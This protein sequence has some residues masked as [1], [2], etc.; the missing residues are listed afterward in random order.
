M[1]ALRPLA[2]LVLTL[3]VTS[4]QEEASPFTL[5]LELQNPTPLTFEGSGGV[6]GYGVELRV[7]GLE[8]GQP[9]ILDP[10]CNGR[11]CGEA[12]LTDPGTCG[13]SALIRSQT[14][15]PIAWDGRYLPRSMDAFGECLAPARA[16]PQG[17]ITVT[18]CGRLTGPSVPRAPLR[19][20][21]H[22]EELNREQDAGD[23]HLVYNV[24]GAAEFETAEP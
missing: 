2:L 3:A 10:E 14:A 1:R 7:E 24:P 16:V 21:V 8:N 19:C 5:D 11:V 18:V 22:Q 9:L 17:P 13:Q 4:C 20:A 12:A 23:I 6:L 15:Q